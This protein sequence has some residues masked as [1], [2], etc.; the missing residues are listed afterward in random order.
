MWL[1]TWLLFVFKEYVHI[2]KLF[3]QFESEWSKE[4]W[5][6]FYFKCKYK[7]SLNKNKWNF[8]FNNDF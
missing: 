8:V 6:K 4:E 2:F 3:A 5:L 7:L 1:N